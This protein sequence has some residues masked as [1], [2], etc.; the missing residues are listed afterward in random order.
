MIFLNIIFI[1]SSNLL[2]YEIFLK[3]NEDSPLL[4]K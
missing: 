2:I 4:S 3:T 1:I